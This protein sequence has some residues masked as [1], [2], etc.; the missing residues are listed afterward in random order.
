MTLIPASCFG[1]PRSE[2]STI[3][4]K[5]SRMAICRGRVI[6]SLS[7]KSVLA[8]SYL[9]AII[10][11]SLMDSAPR[12][13]H[14]S[15]LKASAGSGKTYALSRRFLRFLLSDRI[16]KNS[17]ANILAITFSN[18]AAK[19]MKDRILALLKGLALGDEETTAEFSAMLSMT[20]EAIGAKAAESIEG[21]LLNF[22]DFQIKTIDSFATSIFRS[23]AVDFGYSPDFEIAL[24][25][26]RLFR[27]AFA[28]YMRRV[29]EGSKDGRLVSAVV[30][31]I[32]S[33]LPKESS[34][35]WEPSEKI[36]HEIVTISRLLAACEKPLRV[37]DHGAE[38]EGVKKKI[39][40]ALE[41]ID[42]AI[43]DSE[44]T[45]NSKSTFKSMLSLARSG[46]FR[47]LVGKG[48]KTPP[49]R[50]TADEK[51]G[52]MYRHIVDQ[53]NNLSGLIDSFSALLV[54]SYHIPYLRVYE[55]LGQILER[56]KRQEGIVF[57]EDVGARLAGYM[58]DNVVPDVY[59]RL[60]E[61]VFHYLI[62]EFQDTSPVQWKNLFP[63]L[64]NSLSQG[65]SL[66]VVGDTKQAI[67]G[68]RDADYKIMMDAEKSNPFPSAHHEVAELETNFR[69]DGSIVSFA[70]K[71]FQELLPEH[72]ECVG[73]ATATG[74]LDYRQKTVADRSQQGYVHASIIER[75]EDDGI[76]GQKVCDA[77]SD[78]LAR[79]YR[80]SDIAIL[81]QR[82]SDVRRV[83]MWLNSQRIPFISYSSLD[84]RMRKITGEVLNLM[85]FL[86][87]PVDDLALATFL[88]SDVF[89]RVL[90]LDG[91]GI[92]PDDLQ[93][94]CFKSRVAKDGP[95]YKHLQ[96]DMEGLWLKYFDRLFRL[97]GYLP[98]YDLISEVYASFRLFQL[99]GV[100]EEA[101]LAKVLE[102]IQTLEAG[103]ESDL[104]TFLSRALKDGESD[105]DW[106]ID[107]PSAME[108]VR[109]MTIHKSKGLGFPAVIVLLYGER[110]QGFSY[111]LRKEREFAE[112]L[113]LTK[114]TASA[115]AEFGR[116]Y[117]EER[118]KEM[119]NRL[120]SL[121]VAF[122][123]AGKELHVI[124]VKRE[125]DKLPFSIL[126]S[127]TEYSQGSPC[128]ITGSTTERPAGDQAFYVDA[129][130][131]LPN[132]AEDS[133]KFAE[134]RRGDAVHKILAVMHYV[135]GDL[136][137]QLESAAT[138]V[139][140]QT[141][142]HEQDLKEIS[143]Q[144]A[145]FLLANDLMRYFRRLPDRQVFV[146]CEMVDAEG[147]LF[148]T[149]RIVVDPVITTVIEY[150]TGSETG[151]EE[152]HRS[153]M[154]NYLSLGADLFFRR[155]TE[156]I[157]CYIDSGTVRRL[158]LQVGAD[159]AGEFDTPER[160]ITGAAKQ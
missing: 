106:S 63:L 93:A 116:L 155:Q 21:V 4:G 96:N 60:G 13:P 11:D 45:P 123:R 81:T 126:P 47:D 159:M 22:D 102:A 54:K 138:L 94:L 70:Q 118:T 133:L 113:R 73:A 130:R 119:V 32:T 57:I 85:Q 97:S 135:D 55:G 156:G 137:G 115:D 65:G 16:P 74:L 105:G 139:A 49:V 8:T 33:H 2:G 52:D 82:N 69:S 114:D 147:H 66:F 48:M 158:Q 129:S 109:V 34:F 76:E 103:G 145:K 132:Q 43:V 108:A 122:T 91:A 24:D 23:S 12:F 98:L 19:E 86:D 151:N 127:S 41:W 38:L 1:F 31:F 144:I 134:K 88:L 160:G 10:M 64:E 75:N 62:D 58:S 120:N 87:S 27:Q 80:Y 61:T 30:D 9:S 68:F 28:L 29:R 136:D 35:P 110:N 77:I 107:I 26:T 117:R 72:P 100:K 59:L 5:V 92:T 142:F 36:L 154:A 146:E 152:K 99:F 39:T 3:P 7:R 143:G 124:G 44:L 56:I 149:D 112:L 18:N 104:R 25:S 121:Y 141:G 50:K 78:M 20:D 79:G 150:K 15:I 71:V 17:L 40:K 6:L 153:Q 90:E 53:W 95:L 131:R 37:V 42:R 148:R 51:N 89:S 157:I 128:C 84:V 67:Y 140:A 14:F 111:V 46:H 101:V 83:T 125:K